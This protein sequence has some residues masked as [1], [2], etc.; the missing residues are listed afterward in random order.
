MRSIAE[1]TE[2]THVEPSR[3]FSLRQER[4]LAN[5]PLGRGP[6]GGA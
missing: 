5:R 4:F 2:A 6:T 3:E 1:Q